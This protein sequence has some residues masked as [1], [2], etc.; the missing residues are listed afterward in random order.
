MTPEQGNAAK[1]RTG[2]Q[3]VMETVVDEE[4]AA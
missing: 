2:S 3:G 4:K 1:T